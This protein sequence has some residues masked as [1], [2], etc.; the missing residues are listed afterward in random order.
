[1]GHERR[2]QI[3]RL[4][5]EAVLGDL[6]A[7]DGDLPAPVGGSDDADL[8][9]RTSQRYPRGSVRVRADGLWSTHDQPAAQLGALGADHLRP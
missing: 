9:A 6:V 5:G 2:L 7:R 4:D 3:E 1:V 8:V